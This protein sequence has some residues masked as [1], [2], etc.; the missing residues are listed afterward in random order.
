MRYREIIS[1]YINFEK[2]SIIKYY[3]IT[4]NRILCFD[5]INEFDIKFLI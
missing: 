4:N 2:K 3:V 5:F 1:N